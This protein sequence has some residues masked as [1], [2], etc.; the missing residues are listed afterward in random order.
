MPRSSVV[1]A[2]QTSSGL[3]INLI[4]PTSGVLMAA[5]GISKLSY[6]VWFK[7]VLPLFIIEFFISI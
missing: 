2:M 1:I 3:I 5:L 7:F 6:G 4:T